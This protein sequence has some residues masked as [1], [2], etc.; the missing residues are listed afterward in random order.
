MRPRGG[1]GGHGVGGAISFLDSAPTQCRAWDVCLIHTADRWKGIRQEGTTEQQPKRDKAP[2]S[3]ATPHPWG[4]G[5]HPLS[6]PWDPRA[7]DV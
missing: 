2:P 7:D 3:Q 5:Y 1:E 6:F 4:L